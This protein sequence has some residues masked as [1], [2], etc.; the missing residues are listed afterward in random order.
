MRSVK[1]LSIYRPNRPIAE[2]YRNKL[3][4]VGPIAMHHYRASYA[5]RGICRSRVFVRLSVCLSVSVTSRRSTKI[6][7]HRNTQTTQHE[8]PGTPVFSR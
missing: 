1:C 3:L 2:C 7:Q 5:L 4:S 6:A 8:S